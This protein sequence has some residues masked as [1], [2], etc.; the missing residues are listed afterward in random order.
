MAHNW[1]RV[2]HHYRIIV[3]VVVL[4]LVSASIFLVMRSRLPSDSRGQQ[5]PIDVSTATQTGGLSEMET[6]E[7]GVTINLSEGQAQPQATE[8]VPQATAEPLSPEEIEKIL[9]RLPALTM[10]LGDQVDLNWRRNPSP[11]TAREDH[12]RDL[13]A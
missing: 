2:F 13:P 4:L 7:Q 8:A 10:D 12:R 5:I 3:L 9:A 11:A 6:D 1:K